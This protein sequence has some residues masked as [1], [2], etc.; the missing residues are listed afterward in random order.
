MISKL[1]LQERVQEWSLRED[2]VE[3]DYVLG[4]LLW[5]IGSEPRLGSWVFKGGTCLKKCYIETYRFSE[6][7]D[8][9]I[10][11]GGV[12]EQGALLPILAELLARL[13]AE[14]GLRFSVRP[15]T[16]RTHPSGRYTEG[17]IYYQGPRGAPSPASIRLDLSASEVLARATESRSI[18][19][20]YPDELPP[21]A[22]VQCYSFEELFA[23][24]IRAMGE[25]GRPRDLYDIVNLFR[26]PGLLTS[27]VAIRETL[28]AKCTSKG[29]PVPT[30]ALVDGAPT[31]AELESE[32]ANML[33]HQL[34]A[35]PPFF[36]FWTELEALFRWLE[37][38]A[39]PLRFEPFP[40]S[41]DE[42]PTWAP[43][44]IP[45][46]WRQPVPLESLRFAGSNYLCVELGYQGSRRIIEPY[47]LRQTRDGNLVLHAI[48]V[49]SRA[50]RAYRV[51]RIQ[52]LRVTDRPFR[53]V[54]R[55]EFSSS[56]PLAAK[57]AFGA[58]C[59]GETG[60]LDTRYR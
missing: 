49:D 46:V 39:E 35:L 45:T 41:A 57:G 36:D 6:D 59:G 29:V 10:L 55:V 1:A 11:P 7:L 40:V 25:R 54:Y 23:E 16:L 33:A 43:P 14:S 19:H 30:F 32:W 13:E 21:P 17:R 47:S 50:H 26:H 56:S 3:K 31:R 60:F 48:R 34:P 4:W 44:S 28:I 2:V 52:S 51:D 15:P 37:G 27:P 53:P 58:A 18:I 24:K 42:E 12:Y 5:G 8:F 22:T 9:T 38:T 20:P